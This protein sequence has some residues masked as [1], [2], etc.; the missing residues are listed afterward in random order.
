M[1]LLNV[2]CFT[3]R[4]GSGRE[5]ILKEIQPDRL[6]IKMRVNREPL[7]WVIAG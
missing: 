5:S 4:A 3:T 1:A 7:S 2:T 6:T